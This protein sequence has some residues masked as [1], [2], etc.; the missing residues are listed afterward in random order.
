MTSTF[1][2]IGIILLVL[3]LVIFGYQGLSAFLGMGVSDEFVYENI[4][5]VDIL[6]EESISWIDG[7]SSPSIRSIAETLVYAPLAVWMLGGA[8]LCFLIH[9]FRGTKHIK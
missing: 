8:L 6:G 5:F 2:T 4:S 1:S 3:G 9:A 7:I